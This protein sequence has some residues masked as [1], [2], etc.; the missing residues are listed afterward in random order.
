M[1]KY[2]TTIFILTFLMLSLAA[3]SQQRNNLHDENL[4][5]ALQLK[6]A[7]EGYNDTQKE[8]TSLREQNKALQIHNDELTQYSLFIWC[9]TQNNIGNGTWKYSYLDK[10][11]LFSSNVTLFLI[12]GEEVKRPPLKVWDCRE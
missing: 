4:K 10:E 8:L 11:M 5:L 3:V 7:L 2:F 12:N 6:I 1:F 9:A